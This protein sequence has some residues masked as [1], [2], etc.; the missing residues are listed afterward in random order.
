MD[1]YKSQCSVFNSLLNTLVDI[2]TKITIQQIIS[3][4]SALKSHIA[5]WDC[6]LVILV[7][8]N[9]ISM[10]VWG[11]CVYAYIRVS[12]AGWMC[13]GIHDWVCMCMWVCVCMHMSECVCVC[14]CVRVCVCVC[15]SDCLSVCMCIHGCSKALE[16][17]MQL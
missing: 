8:L 15:L 5:A 4:H 7:E 14:V 11:V 9:W 3:Q 2:Q 13:S 6:W 10:C 1:S 17:I 12:V 16:C